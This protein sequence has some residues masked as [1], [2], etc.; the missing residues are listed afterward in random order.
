MAVDRFGFVPTS[1]MDFSRDDRWQLMTP[2]IRELMGK[3]EHK[4][5]MENKENL[6]ATQFNSGLCRFLV[7]YYTDPGDV[8]LDPFA[9]WGTRAYCCMLLG[10]KYLGFDVAKSTVEAVNKALDG[11][12]QRALDGEKTGS[13]VVYF[14][15]GIRLDGIPDSSADAILTCPPYANREI[16]EA[17]DTTVGYQLSRMDLGY[18]EMFMKR[19]LKRWWTVLKPGGLAVFVVGDWRD[20]AQLYPF[21][22]NMVAWALDAGFQ[23]HDI[24]LHKLRTATAMGIGTF[25]KSKFVVRAHEYVLVFKR[26]GEKA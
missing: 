8:V 4:R 14:A 15:D 1:I 24:I 16:Y 19:G 10:R 17:V 26:P 25:M 2:E 18:F 20:E 11:V 5:G 3:V 13:A 23:F 9:G 7:Q 22:S 6:V 21:A 12:R